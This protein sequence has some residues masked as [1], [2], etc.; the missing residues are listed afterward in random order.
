VGNFLPGKLLDF[1]ILRFSMHF[2]GESTTPEAFTVSY[3][4]FKAG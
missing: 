2:H 4:T 1:V 3:I